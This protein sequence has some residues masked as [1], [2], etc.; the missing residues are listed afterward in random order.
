MI[1]KRITTEFGCYDQKY[2][3]GYPVRHGTL[4]TDSYEEPENPEDWL[5]CPCCNLK[6]R[7]WCFDNGR[8]TACGCSEDWHD[9]FSVHA[10]SIVSCHV[11]CNGSLR[12]YDSDAL[13]KN[14]NDY[15]MTM[16][17]P[18]NHWDLREQGKW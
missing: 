6:P 2:N 12:D 5:E 15:C 8:S 1:T 18:C 14:W 3:H 9:H 16:V 11:R 10:E 7:V 4:C 17:N 13:R